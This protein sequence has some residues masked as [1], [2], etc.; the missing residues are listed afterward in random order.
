MTSLA[1]LA[2][3]LVVLSDF[4][5]LATSRLS[6]CIRIIALQGLLLGAMPLLIGSQMS[7]HVVVL[8]VGTAGSRAARRLYGVSAP[9]VGGAG[10]RV[11][12]R[13][14]A[15]NAIRRDRPARSRRAGD[16]DDRPRRADHA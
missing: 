15:P 11:R 7:V 10:G 6:A 12:G 2:L 8:A 16:G 5:V 1:G 9:R 13:E 3:F 4:A 14:R